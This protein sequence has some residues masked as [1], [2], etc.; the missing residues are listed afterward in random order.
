MIAIPATWMRGGTSKCWVFRRDDLDVPGRTVDEVLLG[1]YGSPDARQVDGV[2]GGTSTT[3][4]AVILSPSD[5]PDIDVDYTFAQVGIDEAV[6]DWG[7]NCGNCSAVVAAFAVYSGWVEPDPSG[8]TT[9]R[10][11]NTNTDQV[12]VQHLPTPGGRLLDTPSVAIPGVPGLGAPVRMG[13]VDPAG[14][15][16]GTL[17]PTGRATDELAAPAGTY[18]VSMVDAGAPVVVVDVTALGY[19]ADQDPHSIDLGAQ[20]LATLDGIRRAGAVAMG[21]APS[22]EAAARAVPK[23]AVVGAPTAE[24]GQ[25]GIQMLSMGTPH[26]AVPITGSVALTLAA[27]TPGTVVSDRVG[28]LPEPAGGLRLDTPAGLVETF[29]ERDGDVDVV[30]AVRTYRRLAEGVAYLSADPADTPP[31]HHVTDD[32]DTEARD[33]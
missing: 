7:S 32:V 22:P 30:G 16:T 25:L 20:T 27:R 13:F 19:P 26:P 15:S 12:I 10:V 3:S 21:L 8:E 1:L 33:A 31:S 9:V 29:A 23:L 18:A 28:A 17:L 2:G 6:V 24:G 11:L 4:K 14:R 5:R